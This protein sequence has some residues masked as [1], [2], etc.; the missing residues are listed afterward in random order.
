MLFESRLHVH[1][2]YATPIEVQ[3]QQQKEA[4]DSIQNIL[5]P[6]V[7]AAVHASGL[8]ACSVQGGLAQRGCYIPVFTSV[9]MLF[10]L[11]RG[12]TRPSYYCTMAA[13][14]VE[15]YADTHLVLRS[16]LT[17]IVSPPRNG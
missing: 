5:P 11:T 10:S 7:A 2:G 14:L 15:D 8:Q 12:H 4:S 3:R 1:E 6:P 13:N 17:L 16:N 9:D